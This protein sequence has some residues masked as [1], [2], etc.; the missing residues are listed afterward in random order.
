MVASPPRRLPFLNGVRAFEAAARAGGFAG[1]AA[2]LHVTPAA[3][4]RMVRLLEL[5]LG[6]ALFE[7]QA[8]RLALTPAGRA[9]LKSETQAL[10]SSVAA[11]TAILDAR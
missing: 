5:R 10:R 3:V 8:N 4:S 6:V 1:A 7:R 9:H 2:E 11:L